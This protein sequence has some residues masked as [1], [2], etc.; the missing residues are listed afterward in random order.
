MQG[1]EVTMLEGRSTLAARLAT[2]TAAR[3]RRRVVGPKL[4]RRS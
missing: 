3:P 1:K 2:A 4:P